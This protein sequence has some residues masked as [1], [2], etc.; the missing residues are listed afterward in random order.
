MLSVAKRIVGQF[1]SGFRT[2]HTFICF[3]FGC[4]Y[5]TAYSNAVNSRKKNKAQKSLGLIILFATHFHVLLYSETH[6]NSTSVRVIL[7]KE[8]WHFKKLQ[9]YCIGMPFGYISAPHMNF[10]ST[11]TYS[12][13][14]RL[15]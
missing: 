14:V 15:L 4:R 9:F 1:S 6:T 2:K 11:F 5:Q 12:V 13:V 10:E 8:F 3:T 7:I